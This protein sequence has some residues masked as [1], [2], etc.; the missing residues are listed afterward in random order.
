MADYPRFSPWAAVVF[1]QSPNT[2]LGILFAGKLQLRGLKLKHSMVTEAP[3][4]GDEYM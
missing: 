4:S 3:S 2:G 1:Q